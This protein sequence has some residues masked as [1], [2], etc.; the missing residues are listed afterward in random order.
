VPRFK[1]ERDGG[2]HGGFRLGHP[3]RRRA[4][5][6]YESTVTHKE[7]ASV[8]RGW[9]LPSRQWLV[10]AISL[11]LC[12]GVV[13]IAL[14]FSEAADFVRFAQQAHPVWLLVACA[15][16]APT[17]GAQAEI[18]RLV[19]RAAGSRLSFADACRISLAKQFVDQALPSAGVSGTVFTAGALDACGLSPRGAWTAVAVNLISYNIVYVAGLAVALGLGR[20]HGR[21][22]AVII[23]VLIVFTLLSAGL[24]ALM[25]FL[26]GR[27]S[28]PVSRRLARIPMINGI[29]K[30]LESA[31]RRLVR[32][33]RLLA[34]AVLWQ[35]AIVALDTLTLMALIESLGERA[36][37]AGAFVSFMIASLVRSMGLVPGGLGTFEASSVVTLRMTGARLSVALA[38]TLMFRGLTFWLPMAPGLW[39]ARRLVP[40]VKMQATTDD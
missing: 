8:A 35:M 6:T 14:H 31:N 38:A 12:A 22:S 7:K 18:W 28:H 30:Q 25:F 24:T 15:C 1:K 20:L 17:Y 23:G 19:A 39:Y 32:D 13:G 5:R 37:L 27:A 11:A 33:P 9:K 16:Q 36:E 34:G 4:R 3:K 26:P 29:A 21:G 2:H 10:W 40:A